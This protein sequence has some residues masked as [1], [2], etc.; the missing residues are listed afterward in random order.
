MLIRQCY[1]SIHVLGQSAEQGAGG[2]GTEHQPQVAIDPG[3]EVLHG[4][5]LLAGEVPLNRGGQSL[6]QSIHLVV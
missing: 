4:V 3:R 2:R 5:R 1:L 6:Q